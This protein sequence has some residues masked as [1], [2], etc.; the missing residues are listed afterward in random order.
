M[1]RIK[2]ILKRYLGFKVNEEKPDFV[3]PAELANYLKS[4][5]W[6]EVQ[7]IQSFVFIHNAYENR[8][9]IF[10]KDFRSVHYDMETDIV[11]K[12]LENIYNLPSGSVLK[13]R[14]NTEFQNRINNLVKVLVKIRAGLQFYGF[15]HSHSYEAAELIRLID[16]ELD[17]W[18][19][20]T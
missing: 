9:L 3:M 5:G 6:I 2:E 4:L 13:I 1:R 11:F 10:P 7:D 15:G 16:K 18:R 14:K 19:D 12:Q 20:V 17:G 8:K